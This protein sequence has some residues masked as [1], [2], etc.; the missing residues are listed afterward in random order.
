MEVLILSIYGFFVWL[1]FIK[2]KWL[3]WN[4]VTQ[5][6]VVV[7]PIV[8][9]TATILMLNV[10]APSSADVRVIKYVVQV[11]PQVRGQV[12]EVP[13]EG[14][15]PVKK[16]AV[17]FRIDPKPYQLEVRALEAQLANA[18]GGVVSQN[19]QLRAAVGKTSSTRAKLDLARAR[20]KQNRELATSGAGD[21][22][23]LEQ[24]T[25]NLQDLEAQMR[26]DLAA[27]AQ[28]R[29]ELGAVVG[30]DQAEIAQIKANLERAKW[31]LTQT[32]FYAPSNGTVINLQLRPGQMATALGM[33]PVMTFVEDQFQVI[34]LFHQNELHQVRPGDLAELALL[35]YPG[36][37]IK[38][39]VD[40]IVWAQGQGQLPMAQ[41]V[42]QTGVAPLPP[43]R[44][45]VRLNIAARDRDVFLA[46][47]AVG[48]GAIYTQHGH[49]IHIIRKV[50][51]RVG[52]YLNWLIL[53]LH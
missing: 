29:A 8:A 32:T 10:Y 30:D 7:I 48:Q 4:T 41:Q 2:L 16:G 14:N 25:T 50:I 42:P 22:F 5:V 28:I 43:G 18:E 47:G 31:E 24:A 46:A 53:K 45:A 33:L 17:L 49:H 3:P 44:F 12:I 23:A 35:T 6:T 1:I 38:A 9:L 40:S 11:V 19:E 26:S 39:S 52:S 21:R 36:R 13:I 15:S 51:L 27:E 20:V 37:I 34:A